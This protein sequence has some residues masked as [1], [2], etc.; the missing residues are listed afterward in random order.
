MGL[1]FIYLARLGLRLA[2]DQGRGRDAARGNAVRRWLPPLQ[3]RR[4]WRARGWTPLRWNGIGRVWPV[5][6]IMALLQGDD[7]L[8]YPQTMA[9]MTRPWGLLP[10]QV[11]DS[12]AIP[13]RE[14]FPGKPTGSAMPL[15]WAHAESLKLLVAREQ[16]RLLELLESAPFQ[17]SLRIRR[18]A[19][20]AGLRL[21]AAW[22]GN[23]RH[24]YRQRHVGLDDR[25]AIHTFL[26]R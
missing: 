15:I 26:P 4:L 3:Q 21:T 24:P 6:R 18:L 25:A 16:N 1:D 10:E 22:V 5:M 14:L 9:R 13:D 20:S 23:A 17:P 8:P 2:D 11:W 12:D 7:T 19:A